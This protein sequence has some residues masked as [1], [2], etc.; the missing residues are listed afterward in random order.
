MKNSVLSDLG[1]VKVIPED[2]MASDDSMASEQVRG[3]CQ[4]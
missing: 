4:T 3:Y 1:M 2:I